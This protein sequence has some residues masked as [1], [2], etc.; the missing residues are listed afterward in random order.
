VALAWVAPLVGFFIWVMFFL[1][2]LL[3]KKPEVLTA[4]LYI[5]K[6]CN[7]TFFF[8]IN[9]I[10][11]SYS[12]DQ[13]ISVIVVVAT[14]LLFAYMYKASSVSVSYL[15]KSIQFWQIFIIYLLSHNCKVLAHEN[16]I[17]VILRALSY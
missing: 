17:T 7:N 4:D 10:Y 12:Y 11:L 3:V 15:F 14:A 2:P 16:I 8:K 13:V 1:L 9:I 5:L 6:V